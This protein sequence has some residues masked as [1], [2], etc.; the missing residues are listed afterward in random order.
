MIDMSAIDSRLFVNRLVF[1]W[2]LRKG[3]S[4]NYNK[5]MKLQRALM[6]VLDILKEL[7]RIERRITE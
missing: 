4:C 1:I 5:V 2:F 3:L 7:D 6:G